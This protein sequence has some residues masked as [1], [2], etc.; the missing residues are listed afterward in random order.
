MEKGVPIRVISRAIDVLK[1]INRGRAVTLSEIARACDLPYP[2]TC[3]IVQTLVCEGIVEAERDRKVYRPTAL[4]QSLSYGFQEENEFAAS[5]RPHIVKLT[6]D[7][8]WPAAIV[9]RVADSM[10]IRDSTHALTTM[11][12]STYYPGY[13][14]PLFESA[15]GK[16]QLAFCPEQELDLILRTRRL[17]T[18]KRASADA[19]ER[20][21]REQLEAIRRAGYAT[22]ER[23]RHTLD[24]G[25]TS[26]ISVP[27]WRNGEL[28]AALTI[29]FFSATHTTA[30]A[31]Q[32]YLEKLLAVQAAID[33]DDS[34]VASAPSERVETGDELEPR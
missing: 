15:S 6:R 25:K 14:L 12:F 9:T 31:A 26:S 22:H 16:V 28:K 10:V 11:T 23:N 21:L 30:D 7:I 3:R 2:T 32:H 8:G 5:V 29:V 20:R 17:K 13:A 19:A 33:H 18:E 34:A 4:A 24:P 1:V 27:L